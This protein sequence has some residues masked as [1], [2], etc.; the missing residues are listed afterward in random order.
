MTILV[1]G[2]SG[3]IGRCVVRQL[4]GAG[5]RVRAMSRADIEVGVEVR[6][7]DFERPASWANALE[8]IRRVY[9]FSAAPEG[10]IEA[11]VSAKVERFVTHSAAAAGFEEH[12][13]KT[14]VG[15]HLNEERGFH[16]DLERAVEASGAEW[17]HVRP[18]L[19]AANAF[20]WAEQLCA[21]GVV[22]GPYAAAGYPWVHEVDVAEIA[23]AALVTD[24]H[25]GAAYTLTG[26]AKVSQAEQVQAI[27]AAVGRELSY[28]EIG[29]DEALAQW[30]KE[31]LDRGTAQWLLELYAD[32][33]EGC[34]ALPPTTT[35]EELTGRSPRTFAQWAR[36]HV[37]DFS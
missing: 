12:D 29:E 10:F 15:R 28:Q 14:A 1:T 22:R 31:G 9:L 23:V 7:G 4:V 32:A 11:A 13:N 27:S 6:Y 19:L 33:V 8:G 30:H 37:R 26:P 18:G 17:T 24:D 20:G 36:D 5:Q 34:G 3:N 35:Y 25:L 16:R 2:A 21:E